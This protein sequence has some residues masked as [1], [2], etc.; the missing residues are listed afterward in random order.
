MMVK[1]LI[2][3]NWIVVCAWIANIFACMGAYESSRPHFKSNLFRMNILFT[4]ANIYSIFYFIYTMQYPYLIL[5]LIFLTLSVKG[6][7]VNKKQKIDKKDFHSEM[8]LSLC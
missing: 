7:I 5:Q 4:I 8:I 2:I 6:I 3:A 1:K